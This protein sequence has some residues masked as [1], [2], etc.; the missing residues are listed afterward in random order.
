MSIGRFPRE[1][2]LWEE[3]SLRLR[4]GV[5]VSRVIDAFT[6][7]YGKLNNL[8]GYRAGTR[9][10]E[11]GRL[12]V[13]YTES[14]GDTLDTVFVVIAGSGGNRCAARF[15]VVGDTKKSLKNQYEQMRMFFADKGSAELFELE[16]WGAPSK[17]DEA[18]VQGRACPR[19]GAGAANEDAGYCWSCG[20]NLAAGVGAP[21][22]PGKA[23]EAAPPVAQGDGLRIC[24]VCH[25]GFGEGDLLAWCPFCGAAAHRVHLLEFL[26][27]NEKCP[28][29]GH[30]LEEGDL[31]KQLG[32]ARLRPPGGRRR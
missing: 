20:E 24:M 10:Y 15:L 16:R 23:A 29:C 8:A 2:P 21:P 17:A 7:F 3:V 26:H 28:S 6:Q 32:E 30:R 13:V 31:A 1:P 12:G 19:C 5:D 9:L 14:G 25:L 18:A 11:S 22:S 27:V 4:P